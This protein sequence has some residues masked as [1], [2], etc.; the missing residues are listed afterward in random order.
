[1]L[2]FRIFS[3]RCYLVPVQAHDKRLTMQGVIRRMMIRSFSLSYIM[4]V[5]TGKCCSEVNTDP[6]LSNL[7]S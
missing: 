7:Q 4:Y 6:D 5:T 2:Y 3:V 1:M